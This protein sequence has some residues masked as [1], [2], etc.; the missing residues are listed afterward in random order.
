MRQE[1]RDHPKSLSIRGEFVVCAF[2]TEADRE[3]RFDP[4]F[5]RGREQ[6]HERRRERVTRGHEPHGKELVRAR[7]RSYPPPDRP[8][9]SCA[10][11][12]HDVAE[13]QHPD[14]KQV[15][16]RSTPVAAKAAGGEGAGVA[17]VVMQQQTARPHRTRPRSAFRCRA[18]A[19]WGIPTISRLRRRSVVAGL[20]RGDSP[21]RRAAASASAGAPR[22]AAGCTK[23]APFR[24]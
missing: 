4:L 6:R 8:Q 2:T 12:A 14:A 23:T 10:C 7:S 17:F 24:L 20:R 5:E 21:L 9:R 1:T 3:E 18:D 11:G 16:S 13:R 15:C 22:Y 19:Q